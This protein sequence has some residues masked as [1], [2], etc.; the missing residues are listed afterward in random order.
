RVGGT[1]VV[2]LVRNGPGPTVL[3]RADMDAV[4]VR[5]Q[6]GLPYES[7]ETATADGGEVPVMH[8]CGHD[9]HVTCLLGAV[10][11]LAGAAAEWSGTLV[12]VFKP[13]E[14]SVD[15]ARAMVEDGLVE[16]VGPVDVA[17]AQHVLAL[18][19]GFVGTRR[20]VV[21][22]TADSACASRCTGGA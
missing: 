2:G 7:T 5:E 13:A 14:E 4:P 1:G 9:V 16:L 6:T 12:A 22:S 21:L 15:G 11:L 10:A 20:G 3:L 18:P 19:A 17:L 8:A